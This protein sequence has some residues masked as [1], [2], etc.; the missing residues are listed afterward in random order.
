[1]VVSVATDWLVGV[2]TLA[3]AA[4]TFV[5][6]G[7]AAWQVW[8][9]RD[10][11]REA[12]RARVDDL[13][14][15]VTLVVRAPSR[16]PLGASPLGDP[17]PWPAGA[18]FT[19]DRDA[20]TRILVRTRGTLVNEGTSTAV[21]EVD[22]A[23]TFPSASLS[24]FGVPGTKSGTII[25]LQGPRWALRPGDAVEFWHN[26]DRPLREWVDGWHRR[27]SDD[28]VRSPFEIR[29]MDQYE[30]GVEDHHRIEV[31]AYPVAPVPGNEAAWRIADRGTEPFDRADVLRVQRHYRHGS[32]RRR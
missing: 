21:V 3:L 6:A 24:A 25:R 4:A 1:V 27:D 12:Y 15:R 5:L 18:Q 20:D 23:V 31:E 2:G 19:M 9:T 8:T 11:V 22:D 10:A 13:A 28:R 7:L 16:P 29:V 17:Q 32:G 14:P 30:N 26:T